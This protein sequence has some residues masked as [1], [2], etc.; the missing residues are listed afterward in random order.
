V[1]TASAEQLLSV[2]APAWVVDADREARVLDLA[3]AHARRAPQACP[4]WGTDSE[5]MLLP[6][7][8]LGID[9]FTHGCRLRVGKPF[10]AT[11]PR[12][13]RLCTPGAQ[14]AA[15]IQSPTN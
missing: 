5:S 2:F 7:A 9:T 6:D 4:A 3:L 8:G 13:P 11:L 12:R 15:P 1:Y 14:T 10:R